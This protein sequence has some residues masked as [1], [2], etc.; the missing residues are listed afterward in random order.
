MHPTL[1]LPGGLELGSH[2]VFVGLGVAVALA[3]LGVAVRLGGHPFT[4]AARRQDLLLVV[5]LGLAGGALGMRLS[6]VTAAL[7]TPHSDTGVDPLTFWQDGSKSVLGGLTLA[8]LGV[9]LG[10]RLVGMRERTGDL[11]APAVA[12]GMAVGRIGCLLTEPPGRTTSLPWAVHLDAAQVAA[13]PAC[14]SCAVGVGLH[15]SFAYEIAFHAVAFAV[16]AALVPARRR[17]R[18][19][20]P[21]GITL[22]AYL[23][24]YAAFRFGVEF[25][26]DVDVLAWGLTRAQLYLGAVVLVVGSGRIV[27]GAVRLRAAASREG[28]GPTVAAGR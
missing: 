19:H 25:T 13:I 11:F 16:L 24:C 10:K 26:R 15:P 7:T 4:A 28:A 2:Q 8:Y 6:T 21:D 14:R 12:A 3:V 20:L 1:T 23:A 9:L 27:L 5:A 22:T 17:G 18:V